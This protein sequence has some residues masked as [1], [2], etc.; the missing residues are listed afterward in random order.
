MK[1]KPIRIML[2]RHVA[3]CGRLIGTVETGSVCKKRCEATCA[4]LSAEQLPRD[5]SRDG[6]VDIMHSTAGSNR[7][8][9]ERGE[10]DALAL[11]IGVY[12][13]PGYRDGDTLMSRGLY[14]E[15]L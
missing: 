10:H 12:K 2:S 9:M 4:T 7:G 6:E 11:G 8:P 15:A 14:D 1:H 13:E 5:L 3:F